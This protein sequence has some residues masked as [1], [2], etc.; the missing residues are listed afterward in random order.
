MFA[1]TYPTVGCEMIGV[2]LVA[3]ECNRS[4]CIVPWSFEWLTATA[5]ILALSVLSQSL[6][7]ACQGVDSHL[8]PRAP[9][10]SEGQ[11]GI[12][13]RL[14]DCRRSLLKRNAQGSVG[15]AWLF[16]GCRRRSEDFLYGRELQGF[17]A[18]STLTRLLVAF[19]RAGPSKVYVQHLLQEQVG[20]GIALRTC[21]NTC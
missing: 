13:T 21:P 1:A 6:P 3:T 9:V 4:L 20:P 8:T 15:Q 7:S 12:L 18:D 10:M 19:S 16:C 17:A 2:L 11:P 14:S 5:D